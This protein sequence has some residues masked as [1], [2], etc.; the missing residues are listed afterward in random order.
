[1]TTALPPNLPHTR[2]SNSFVARTLSLPEACG[3]S[4]HSIQHHF[5]E[6]RLQ[7]NL[8]SNDFLAVVV[9]RIL[10]LRRRLRGPHLL[11]AVGYSGARLCFNS[12][13]HVGAG[14]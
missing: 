9:T 12:N 5:I 11:T 10:A 13:L 7:L 1:M 6:A 14:L 3:V 2:D 4:V 8:M